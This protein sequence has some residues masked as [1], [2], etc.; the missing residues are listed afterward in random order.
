MKAVHFGAGNIGRGFVGLLLHEAGYEVVFADVADA[1]I[2]Q[3][4]AADSYRVHEVGEH[5]TVRT[6]ENFR[7]LNSSSQ[8]ADVIAEITTA[9]VVTTAVGPHILKFVAPVIAKGIAARAAGLAPLQVMAC[10]NAINATDIL[11]S[12]VA[13]QW[14]AAA[15][16]LEDKAVFAN[17][18][19][20]RIVP[21]QEAG[22][23]LDV[24]VENFYEWVIDRTPFAGNPPVI[25]GATFVDELEPYIERKLFT[26][27][28][29][30]A[31]AAYFGFE[32]GLEKISEAMADQDVAADV[33]AV[34][35]ETKE[36]L[37]AKHGFNRDEQEAY[38]Q[39]ILGRFS[40][41]HLPD[42]VNRV[43]R[44]P[45][46]KLSRHERF[47]GPAA[48][49]AERGIVPEAL[50]GAIAA[51]LRF[52]DPADAEAVE[53][54]QILA[55]STAEEATAKITGLT[56]DHPLF[57]AVAALVEDARTAV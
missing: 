38:V 1:L 5:P 23:G 34:L 29:G 45:L 24:T 47:I 28:T 52:N 22:Q 3:L 10:E 6:V 46:R 2:T 33:R 18:A 50:L 48:E 42:T 36:L 8:E 43:G 32:A 40:N 14:D 11:K 21:N 17:T 55:S 35:D 26:V 54:G 49:L 37:V 51:A 12:E 27:N 19:V 57:P 44:A 7:A 41:P 56:P 30:H 4:A 15:G 9:D 20:D 16:S 39:K 31:A 13:A 53:L 25:P